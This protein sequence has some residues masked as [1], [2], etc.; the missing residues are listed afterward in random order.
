M[1]GVCR[2]ACMQAL[3]L[4]SC[5]ACVSHEIA[6]GSPVLASPAA[7]SH[8]PRHR[9]T[10]KISRCITR[11]AC[12]ISSL[13]GPKMF[14]ITCMR[15]TCWRPNTRTR[16]SC[17]IWP[18]TSRPS[19][20]MMRPSIF[21]SSQLVCNTLACLLARLQHAEQMHRSA[22]VKSHTESNRSLTQDDLPQAKCQRARST[23]C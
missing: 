20:R 16:S 17:S 21:T 13:G 9:P 3:A 11:W 10:Q 6:E 18:I 14:A 19:A 23:G 8:P 4:T 22:Q 5:S 15:H 7:H 12:C 2:P 1:R